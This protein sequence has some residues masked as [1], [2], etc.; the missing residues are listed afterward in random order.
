MCDNRRDD[1]VR[2]RTKKMAVI[3]WK[4]GPARLTPPPIFKEPSTKNSFLPTGGRFRLCR[5]SI[6]MPHICRLQS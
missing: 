3:A 6:Q 5:L 1:D 2:G 4:I